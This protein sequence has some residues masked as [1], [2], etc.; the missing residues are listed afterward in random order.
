MV[1]ILT[2]TLAFAVGILWGLYIDKFMLIV[3]IFL[4]IAMLMILINFKFHK[5]SKYLL[6]FIFLFSIFIFGSLYTSYV[7]SKFNSK[8]VPRQY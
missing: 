6:S 8:Y 1:T 2:C 3:P 4:F 7:L 5:M